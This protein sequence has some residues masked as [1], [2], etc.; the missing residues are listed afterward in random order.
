VSQKNLILSVSAAG[1]GQEMS[2]RSRRTTDYRIVTRGVELLRF[3]I[4]DSNLSDRLREEF[5]LALERARELAG[6]AIEIHKKPAKRGR[7]DT[8]PLDKSGE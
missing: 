4:L 3:G 1:R 6:R 5:G 2:N 8:K 7:L